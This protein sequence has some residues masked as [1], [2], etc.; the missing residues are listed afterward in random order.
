MLYIH[1]SKYYI[2]LCA[3]KKKNFINPPPAVTIHRHSPCNRIYENRR[4]SYSR[5]LL[6]HHIHS[7]LY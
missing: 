6:M 7:E 5:L 4:I 3:Q 1:A 2:V